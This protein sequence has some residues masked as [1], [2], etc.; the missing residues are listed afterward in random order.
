MWP[1]VWCTFDHCAKSKELLMNYIL[2]NNSTIECLYNVH[3]LQ[4]YRNEAG[5]YG[6][7][8]LNYKFY[9][10]SSEEY[11]MLEYLELANLNNCHKHLYIVGL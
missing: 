11:N 2:N 6:F 3:V 4:C 8:T 9:H 1:G 10:I 7:Y 5:L